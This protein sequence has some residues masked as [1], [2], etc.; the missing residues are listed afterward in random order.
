MFSGLSLSRV[1]MYMLKM[2]MVKTLSGHCQRMII[3]KNIL[4]IP[5]RRFVFVHAAKPFHH[6]QFTILLHLNL[7]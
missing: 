6:K 2:T 4:L 3:N 1:P 7:F 5:A